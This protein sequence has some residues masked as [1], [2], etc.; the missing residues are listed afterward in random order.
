[1]V[2]D[3]LREESAALFSC[4]PDDV[5]IFNSTTEALNIIAWSLNLRNGTIVSTDIEFPSVTYP[6]MRIARTQD[7]D[8]VL[9]ESENWVA[10]EVS[11]VTPV[12]CDH[13]EHSSN[14]SGL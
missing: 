6:W 1:M 8:V 9:V 3:N 12:S 4:T 14:P 5:A 11:M 2:Y 13:S 7:L 10:P